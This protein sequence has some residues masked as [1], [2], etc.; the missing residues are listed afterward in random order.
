MTGRAA[1]LLFSLLL[2]VATAGEVYAQQSGGAPQVQVRVE[3]GAVAAGDT[4]WV[5]ITVTSE[6]G[7]TSVGLPQGSPFEVVNRGGTSSS[8]QMSTSFGGGMQVTRQES[9]RWQ[10]RALRA[11]NHTIGPL[12]VNLGGQQYQVGSAEMRV[13][14]A[15][16]GSTPPS[17]GAGM[18]PGTG[19]PSPT[20]IGRTPSGLQGQIEPSEITGAT[21]DNELFLRT[22]LEPSEAYVGQQVV[23]TV[24]LYTTVQLAN[25]NVTREPSTDGFWSE[26]LLG[27]TRRLSF[28][29]QFVGQQQFRVAVLRRVALFPLREGTLTV[30]APQLEATTA[31]RS[32]FSPRAGT[33]VRQG[34]PVQLRAIPL[35]EQGQPDDFNRGNV[36]RLGVSARVDRRQTKV[37]EPVTLTV[38]VRG[39][40]HL[41]NVKIAPLSE[42]DGARVY[43]PRVDDAVVNQGDRL[44]GE[45]RWEYLVLPQKAGQ[46]EIPTVTFD[47]FDPTTEQYMAKH[48]KAITIEVGEGSG[49]TNGGTPGAVRDLDSA[50]EGSGDPVAEEL[51]SLHS[52]RRRA[53]LTE[54][55]AP[56][57]GSW[58]F[59]LLMIATPAAFL[60]LVVV[61]RVRHHREATAGEIRARRASKVA[62]KALLEV[63]SL[64]GDA[65]ISR[66]MSAVNEFFLDRFEK[67]ATGQTKGELKGFLL[68]RGASKELAERMAKL[69]ESCEMAR[70]GG[71]SGERATELAEE[72]IILINELDGLKEGGES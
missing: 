72:A 68:E 36:G 30:G 24:Y 37:G 34:V 67:S 58:W 26:D 12:V 6:T 35:P 60:T 5:N 13:I 44:I 4:F 1:A 20:D 51:A 63:G 32:I 61:Q 19:I 42:V 45:R 66:V 18:S 27:P 55:F 64:E 10:L 46:L 59:W 49:R 29:T 50:T 28:E 16:P 71:G 65:G 70:F 21:F 11:G 15:P 31:F 69:M 3:Q 56:A 54:E 38:T 9:F 25:V 48:T 23:M 39:Q 47:Y 53:E 52:I 2:G 43:E 7:V 22:V 17:T 41:K 57:Y 62:R 33:L 40:G 8:F 14:E